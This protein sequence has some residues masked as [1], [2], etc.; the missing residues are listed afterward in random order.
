MEDSLL[1]SNILSNTHRLIHYRS[2]ELLDQVDF[3]PDFRVAV[4]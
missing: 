2:L 4:W 1:N 3:P